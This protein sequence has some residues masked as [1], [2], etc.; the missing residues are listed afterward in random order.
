MLAKL[1]K[2]IIIIN[3]LFFI[4]SLNINSQ[5]VNENILKLVRTYDYINALYVDSINQKKIV[6]SAIKAMLNE[7][8]P[9][10]SYMS[11]EEVKE[12]NEPLQGNFEGIGVMFN[13][14]NDTIFIINVIAGG[15]SEKVGVHAGDK[16]I[17][18]DGEN[19]AGKKITNKTVMSKL[20]G[21]KGTKVTI[22]VLRRGINDLIDYTIVR[23]KIPIT[24]IDAAYMITPNTGYIKLDRFAQTTN[25]EFETALKKLMKQNASNLI[26]DLSGNGGGYL[27][28]AVALAD[29]FLEKDKLI[30]Y[31]KGL[32]NPRKEYVSTSYGLFEKGKLVIIVDESSASASEILAGAI[33]DWDRGIIVGRRSFGKGLVQRPLFLPDESMIRLTVAYYYTPS[34]RNIQKPFKKGEN[35]EYEKDLYNRYNKGEMISKDS[36]HFADSLR[37]YTLQKKRIVYGGGGI[38]PDI[39][40]PIDTSSYSN[41]YRDILRNGTLNKFVLEY[42][43]KNRA[44]IQRK[45]PK[46]EQFKMNF[47]A[48]S[49]FEPFVEYAKLDSIKVDSTQVQTSKTNIIKLIKANIARDI[50][51]TSEFFEIYNESDPMVQEAIKAIE[52]Y[53]KLLNSDK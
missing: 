42:I 41:F 48:S 43:D 4:F 26:I 39:F 15:P 47:D 50:W 24:S 45:Y 27:E 13:I 29:H 38:M 21:K 28:E 17:K 44:S 12:L 23:D 3:V 49:L 7:L 53:D 33:Q 30:V 9:H 10:S 40:V 34:G 36:I 8:D 25:T 6:E 2:R 14:L 20:R 1:T 5:I 37:F 52:D 11:P 18:I 51:N 32:R 31:T 46:F 19:V 16:I 22:S 35:E